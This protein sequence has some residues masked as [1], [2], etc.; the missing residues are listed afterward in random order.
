MTAKTRL[1]HLERQRNPFRTAEDM[2]DRELCRVIVGQWPSR[3]S[4][5][6]GRAR[7]I[8]PHFPPYIDGLATCSK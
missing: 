3:N 7:R 4:V 1:A 6:C 8:R 5:T 2:T